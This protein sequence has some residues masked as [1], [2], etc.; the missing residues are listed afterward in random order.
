MNIVFCIPGRTYS[1]NFLL[2]W[3]KLLVYCLKNN[4]NPI[5]CNR[6]SSNVYYVR[7]MCLGG[8]VSS[9]IYQKP[10]K[11]KLNYDYIMWI[12]S[13]IVFTI[14]DFKNLLK[15]QKNI[16]SGLY[17]MNKGISFAT[18]KNWDKNFYK[19]NGYFKFLT[20]KDIKQHVKQNPNTLLE[21]EYT[22]FGWMLIKKGVFEKMEY[23]WFRPIWEDFGKNENDDK[24]KEFTSEDVGWCQTIL[25]KGFKIYV[26]PN[27]IVGHEKVITYHPS[28][29]SM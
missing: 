15:H 27:I 19:K 23:P 11:G 18:V 25:K 7:N 5:I 12:D 16:V 14:K 20:Y 29:M 8:D 1:N 2:C 22:G 24:I 9:G 28:I 26:D 3:S 13:D 4:I 10:F 6:T 21:V 17:L